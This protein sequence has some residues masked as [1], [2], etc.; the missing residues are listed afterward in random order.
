MRVLFART[1]ALGDFVTVVPTLER[2]VEDGHVVTVVAPPRYRALWDRAA[3]WLDPEGREVAAWLAG[4]PAEVDLAIAASPTLRGA[5]VG[6]PQVVALDAVPAGPA[7]DHAWD[8]VGAAL[9]W[10]PRD[11]D[12]VLTPAAGAQARID[13]RLAGRRPVVLSPGS[14]G[15]SKRGPI[16]RWRALADAIGDV[17][18]VGGPVEAGEPGWGEPRWDDLGLADLV[19]LAARCRAWVA[20]DSG[21]AH[22]AAAA[23]A[24]TA[25]LFRTTDPRIWAPPGSAAFPDDTRL[26]QLV[27]WAAGAG[28]YIP[29]PATT[30][31][32]R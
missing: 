21:P 32:V 27:T 8:R 22:V 31:S 5:L 6:V 4:V 15:A 10:G 29:G 26:D 25:V 16:A 9:G 24:P 28:R 23:G 1:G 12:P 18:W 11:R 19:A 2:L 20:P 17:V 3:R 13:A 14:G 30:R 7:Y